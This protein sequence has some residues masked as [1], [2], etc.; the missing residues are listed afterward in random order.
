VARKTPRPVEE[1]KSH[2]KGS[3]RTD[4][5]EQW[6]T[7]RAG[8][9]TEVESCVLPEYNSKPTCRW[10]KLHS[11]GSPTTERPHNMHILLDKARSIVGP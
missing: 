10:Q 6:I 5:N 2:Y 11:Y 9:K 7:T 3:P 8:S 1:L 4:A